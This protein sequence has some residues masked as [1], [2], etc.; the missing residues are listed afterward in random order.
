MTPP[1]TGPAILLLLEFEE[2]EVLVDVEEVVVEVVELLGVVPATPP[3]R[4]SSYLRH[5]HQEDDDGYER[6][7]H[8]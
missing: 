5:K 4:L 7:T 1:A 6:N 3:M 8:V 2:E